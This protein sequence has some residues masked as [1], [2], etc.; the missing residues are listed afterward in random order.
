MQLLALPALADNYIWLLHDDAGDA[1]V[2]DPGDAEVV[3][4]ALVQHDLR[5]RSILLTH[6]HLD[7]IGGASYLRDRH[8]ASV[9]AP[10]DPRIEHVDYRIDD[11]DTVALRSPV[12]QFRVI[13]VPGHTLTHIAF[14]GE[15]RLFCGDTLFSLGCGRLFEGTPEQMLA[16]LDRLAKL[17]ADTLVCCAHEYTAANGRFALHLD[18]DNVALNQRVAE[19]AELRMRNLP[20]L[21]VSLERERQTNPFLRVDAPALIAWGQQQG[22]GA[23]DRV[24]RFAAIRAAKDSFQG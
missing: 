11:G 20:S 15:G 1:L 24:G 5:L 18:G 22:I 7:H 4:R 9:Y 13:G 23:S 3:E 12:A 19:V 10:H 14:A 21:P 6:H 2:V 16:S 17:P 8:Q